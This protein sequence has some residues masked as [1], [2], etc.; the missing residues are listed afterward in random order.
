MA[1][2]LSFLGKQNLESFPKNQLGKIAHRWI[3]QSERRPLPCSISEH[4]SAP[5]I[6]ISKE[7]P[8][9]LSFALVGVIQDPWNFSEDVIAIC[10]QG[11]QSWI[12]LSKWYMLLAFGILFWN[13]FKKKWWILI[14]TDIFAF[15]LVS[16]SCI[17]S[18]PRF[19]MRAKGK[20]F[21]ICSRCSK[22]QDFADCY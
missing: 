10:H 18:H 4:S 2:V 21:K 15:S 1:S 20:M 11:K 6:T 8:L 3:S 19:C 14:V 13:Q 16:I 12:R 5:S 9:D 17:S 22:N 7:A